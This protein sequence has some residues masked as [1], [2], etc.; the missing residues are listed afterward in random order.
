M[1]KQ[2][3]HKKV[4][5]CAVTML[6]AVALVELLCLDLA[7]PSTHWL[8]TEAGKVEAQPD[9]IFMMRQPNDFVA[10]LHQEQ[11]FL[12]MNILHEKLSEFR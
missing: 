5:F 4:E 3:D 7:L 12:D 9:S 1:K 6:L 2:N 10:F 11:R 8:V